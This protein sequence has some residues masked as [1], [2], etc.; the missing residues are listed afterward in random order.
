MTSVIEGRGQRV[1]YYM[2]YVFILIKYIPFHARCHVIA[3]GKHTLC[4]ALELVQEPP[5]SPGEEKSGHSV[6][7]DLIHL[8]YIRA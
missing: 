3:C 8:F 7:V 6:L 4:R 1:R 2:F 5:L